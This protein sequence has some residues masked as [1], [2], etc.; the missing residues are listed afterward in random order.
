M[1]V[2]FIRDE[3]CRNK[4]ISVLFGHSIRY[5]SGQDIN[6]SKQHIQQIHTLREQYG[7][8][9]LEYLLSEFAPNIAGDYYYP[10]LV[11]AKY[12]TR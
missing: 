9:W 6:L 1:D 7:D 4:F 3:N 12:R 5:E 8:G 2:L 11:S 10:K